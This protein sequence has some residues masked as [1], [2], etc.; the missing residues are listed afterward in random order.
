MWTVGDLSDQTVEGSIL[1]GCLFAIAVAVGC[2][3]SG[4]RG[5]G[6]GWGRAE[7]I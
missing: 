4:G 5:R 1:T 6:R 3:V 7:D 2:W